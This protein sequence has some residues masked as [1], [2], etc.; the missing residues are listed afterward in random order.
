M[1]NEEKWNSTRAETMLDILVVIDGIMMKGNHIII[2]EELQKQSL[3]TT[4]QQP[5]GY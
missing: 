5:H 2:P 3:E 4:A 1:A